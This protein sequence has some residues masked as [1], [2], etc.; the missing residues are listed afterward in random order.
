[1][2]KHISRHEAVRR[3][4][5]AIGEWLKH[6]ELHACLM[7]NE[8]CRGRLCR[9][10]SIQH[11]RVLQSIASQN[12]VYLFKPRPS[13]GFR[14]SRVGIRTATT[15]TG[16]CEHHDREL[17]AAIDFGDG[18]TFDPTSKEQTVLLSLR[19]VAMEYWKKLNME[20]LHH[21]LVSCAAS[22]DLERLQQILN[23]DEM[24]ARQF[25]SSVDDSARPY[26]EGIRIGVRRLSRVYESLLSQTHKG[27]F[28]LSVVRVYAMEGTGSVATSS[29]FMPEYDFKGIKLLPLHPYVDP[30]Y[31]AL[32]VIPLD[33]R[34]WVAFLWH[35][36]FSAQL[37]SL[38]S[39]LDEMSATERAMVLS[40]MIVVHCENV[41][42]APHYVEGLDED[43]RLAI[44]EAFSRT[45]L[46][47]SPY[48][49]VREVDFFGGAV[50]AV[51]WP[52]GR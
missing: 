44:E 36:R 8:N 32:N 23:L 10:H 37:S 49:A 51:S 50:Q 15:F 43:I 13:T 18:R 24:H 38:F 46:E 27:K 2:K 1:M 34:T 28:H 6:N 7:A 16:F 42:L 17:F 21:L 4:R 40:K 5:A 48:D 47:A 3:Y 26:L 14:L 30:Y 29:A 33:G 31:V 52:R 39:Q 19:A 20:K 11:K 22:G 41:A 25:A 12:Q 45:V 35:R 9:S